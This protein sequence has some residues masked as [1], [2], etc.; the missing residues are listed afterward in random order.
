MSAAELGRAA[1]TAEQL[2]DYL[3]LKLEAE[4]SL[5]SHG[6]SLSCPYYRALDPAKPSKP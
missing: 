4:S 2:L 6:R 1:F 5:A 3:P